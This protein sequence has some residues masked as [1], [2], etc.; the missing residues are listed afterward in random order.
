MLAVAYL[1]LAIRQQIGCWAAAIHQLLPLC[2]GDV[3]RPVHGVV[4]TSMPPWRST[5]TGNGLQGGA[6]GLEVALVV[7]AHG[8]GL[9]A[10]S[11]CDV[12]SFFLRASLL[13]RG[14]SWIPCGVGK[15]VCDLSGGAQGYENW[16]WWSSRLVV[17]GSIQPGCTS[18]AVVRRTCADN[19]GMREWRAPWSLRPM[20]CS[21]P[22][23]LA[24]RWYRAG[25]VT[26]KPLAAGLVNES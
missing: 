19:R 7:V 13:P 3:P 21:A 22:E 8:L 9:L 12:S 26:L 23:E 11:E 15:R 24:L 16:Y 18:H 20:P 2:L 1:L 4:S 6:A 17:H 5:A 14:P 10:S 25:P